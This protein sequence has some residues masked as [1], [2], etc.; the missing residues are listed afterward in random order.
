MPKEVK[1]IKEF[2]QRAH[3]KDAKFVKIMKAK[4]KNSVGKAKDKR[5][6]KDKYK[7]KVRCSRYLYTL[8]LDDKAKAEKLQ[9]SLPPQ[10]IQKNKK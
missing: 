7:F 8:K 1:E 5:K 6:S 4:A 3:S 2:L 9:Q 10:L